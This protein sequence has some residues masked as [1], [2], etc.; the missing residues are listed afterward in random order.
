[1]AQR[2]VAG[3]LEYVDGKPVGVQVFPNLEAAVAVFPEIFNGSYDEEFLESLGLKVREVQ[4][5]LD[6]EVT[7]EL[8]EPLTVSQA[9][10]IVDYVNAEGNYNEFVLRPAWDE[11]V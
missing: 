11:E 6:E 7:Y 10:R 4:G 1:M 2:V 8:A 3:W 5:D 9:R